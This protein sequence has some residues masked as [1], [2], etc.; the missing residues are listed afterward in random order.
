MIFPILF[1]LKIVLN[2]WGPLW[3][4]VNFRRFISFTVFNV[5]HHI[6]SRYSSG[7]GPLDGGSN[8]NVCGNSYYI[9]T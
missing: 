3:L 9:L 6:T 7:M 8:E 1:L 5:Q 4:C 2:I